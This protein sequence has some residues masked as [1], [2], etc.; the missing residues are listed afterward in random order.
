MDLHEYLMTGEYVITIL[1]RVKV[2]GVY[3]HLAI[4][5]KRIILFK[6]SKS[7]FLRRKSTEISS[8][9]LYPLKGIREI[10]IQMTHDTFSIYYVRMHARNENHDLV[11][12][13]RIE[14][15]IGR[16]DVRTVYGI[17]WTTLES[18][19]TRYETNL[20]SEL[21]IFYLPETLGL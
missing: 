21:A 8:L 3:D 13:L 1:D 10:S 17:L 15:K 2:D 11:F 5:N 4:T 18:I 12:S 19:S 20:E 6:T 14:P 16:T 7:G 9:K